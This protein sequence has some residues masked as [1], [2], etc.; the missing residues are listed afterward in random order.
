MCRSRGGGSWWRW[1]P[2]RWLAAWLSLWLCGVP[3]TPSWSLTPSERLDSIE[4]RLQDLSGSLPAY[5][6]QVN[7]FADSARSSAEEASRLRQE[8]SEQRLELEGLRSEL[9]AWKQSWADSA[10]QVESLLGKVADLQSR[11]ASLTASFEL[12]VGSWK[13]AAEVAARKARIWK[14]LAGAGILV[15]LALGILGGVALDRL[16]QR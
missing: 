6:L 7:S 5:V 9:A 14:G 12:T 16:I 13:K 11:L 15:S 10:Q 2:A 1:L 8:L 3:I 4:N